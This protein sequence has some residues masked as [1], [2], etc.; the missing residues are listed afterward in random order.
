MLSKEFLPGVEP[1]TSLNPLIWQ[2]QHLDSQVHTA[3]MNIAK[4]FYNYLDID[5]E[6]IDVIVTG[7][8]ASYLYTP[9]SDLDLHIIVDYKEVVC[10]QPV[11][12]LFDTKRKLWKLIHDVKVHDIPVEC[13][14]EDIHKPV[15][16]AAYSILRKKWIREPHEP[17]D[18]H[19]NDLAVKRE[20]RAWTGRIQSAINTRR[21]DVVEKAKLELM[22][23]RKQGLAQGGELSIQNL[24]YK[25][26]R[27][28]GVVTVLFQSLIKLQDLDM[29]L[30]EIVDTDQ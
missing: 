23:Y 15:K 3:L 7:S 21:A 28:T 17:V 12:E 10:D 20:A 1:H 25:M 18:Y 2:G 14:A 24:V 13:Y 29:T 26:L 22:N 11:E 6:V 16:G 27:N 30:P 9:H 19:P 8:Q 4:K 5:V